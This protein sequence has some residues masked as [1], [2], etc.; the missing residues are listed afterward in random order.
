MQMQFSHR[1][2]SARVATL[3][4]PCAEGELVGD[5]ASAP[6]LGARLREHIPLPVGPG[7]V[8][9]QFSTGPGDDLPITVVSVIVDGAMAFHW[10]LD[11]S[12]PVTCDFLDIWNA[13]KGFQVHVYHEGS[14]KVLPLVLYLEDGMDL[15][16]LLG[17]MRR[18]CGQ[19]L[20]AQFFALADA[21]CCDGAIE[22]QFQLSRPE[23]TNQSSWILATPNVVGYLEG[24]PAAPPPTSNM[25]AGQAQDCLTH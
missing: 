20:T 7:E 22:L 3:F 9:F 13:Q 12:D 17:G 16:E 10:F 25:C 8:E 19:E 14:E 11:M 21:M 24:F 18:F 6:A 2:Q 5:F 4:N 15:G 1:V 23:L